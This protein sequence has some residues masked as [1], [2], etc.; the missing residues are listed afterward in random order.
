MGVGLFA[1][2][3]VLG[4]SLDSVR[5]AHYGRG[6]GDRVGKHGQGRLLHANNQA[7]AREVVRNGSSG[8]LIGRVSID[9]VI[10]RLYHDLVVA[11]G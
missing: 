5:E 3:H 11:C 7:A 1:H 10:R 8:S 9:A 4:L 6:G 2:L